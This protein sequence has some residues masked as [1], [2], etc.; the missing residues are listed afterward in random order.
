MR[1]FHS[2]EEVNKDI[3]YYVPRE[4]LIEQTYNSLLGEEPD[5]GG[6]YIT[7][8]GPRQSG[9]SWV[10]REV[11]D[12]LKRRDDFEVAILS[13]QFKTIK[14]DELI[15]KLLVDGL[16][17]WFDRDLPEVK[18]W[19][20]LG[21]LFSQK[22]FSK[23]L[24]L[25]LDEFDSIGDDFIN[26][27]ATEFRRLHTNRLN[28]RGVPSSEK[29]C[30]LH[31]LALIGVRSVLGIEN[32]GGGSPFNVQRSMPIPNLT[33]EEVDSM[34]HWYERES[35]QIVEQSVIDQVFYE[36][37]GQPGLIGWMGEQLT[38]D[39]FNK[40]R[41]KPINMALFKKVYG[42]ALYILPNNNIINLISKARQEPY[43]QVVLKLFNTKK[44]LLFRYDDTVL[45]F[46]YM[47]GIINWEKDVDEDE[48]YYTKFPCSFVQRRL[49]NAFANDI[50]P[51]IGQTYD[52]FD[53][54]S[55][56]VTDNSLNITNLMRHY[57]IYLR[58]NRDWL[59]KDAPR[60]ETDGR[61]MEATYHFNL[62]LYLQDFLY[63]YSSRIHPEFP[64][65]NGRIDLIID[66]GNQRYGLEVKSFSGPRGYRKALVDT[67]AYG[68]QLGLA[69]ISLVFFCEHITDENRQ[70][71]EKQYQDAKTNVIVEP[72]FVV[73]G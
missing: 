3:H 33:F 13:M 31:S 7:V 35:G 1:K 49:F 18:N 69:E 40:D 41:T 20:T 44:K 4:E 2:Y 10:M 34:F 30:L 42:A 50:F 29:L 68:K 47:N 37:Q 58:Q 36:M 48:R 25:I 64:T 52:P 38:E 23:P 54:L 24:I 21:S 57:E 73:V 12:K 39:R 28:Q 55:N 62:Y 59:L 16:S 53:D 8:W 17:E 43:K 56:T 45:N 65:G 6:H 63:D 11:V 26:K 46:L 66:H 19:H 72:V 60:R 67:A 5:Y 32:T 71:Y 70:K 9:K 22:Y 27:F 14:T 61:I 51:H 15:L